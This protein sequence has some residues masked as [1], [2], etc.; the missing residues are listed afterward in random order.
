[1]PN[2]QPGKIQFVSPLVILFILSLSATCLAQ[3]LSGRPQQ[4]VAENFA[5]AGTRGE[6]R[7]K[8]QN[9]KGM[10]GVL[11]MKTVVLG[12]DF[13][14]TTIIPFKGDLAEYHHLEI[15]RP[16]SLVGGVLTPQ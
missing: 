7:E 13:R 11:S 1:M 15:A 12:G 4:D 14:V 8:L 5:E 2:S 3:S 9:Y 6:H 10:N 16:V